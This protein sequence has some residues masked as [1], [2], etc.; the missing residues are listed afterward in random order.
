MCIFTSTHGGPNMIQLLNHNDAKNAYTIKHYPIHFGGFG[1]VRF[2]VH[3]TPRKDDDR[4]IQQSLTGRPNTWGE[5]KE[6][7]VSDIILLTVTEDHD[8]MDYGLI[9]PVLWNKAGK[10]KEQ[11]ISFA[12]A[13]QFNNLQRNVIRKAL[14]DI[15]SS[16]SPLW[17]QG[18]VFDI[19]ISQ[20]EPIFKSEV[21]AIAKSKLTDDERRLRVW[22]LS[23]FAGQHQESAPAMN[24]REKQVLVNAGTYETA[25]KYNQNI[26]DNRIA[27]WDA[28]LDPIVL[29]TLNIRPEV[30][31]SIV[32]N[33]KL[34]GSGSV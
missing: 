18:D 26:W 20:Q 16:A 7:A 27:L 19:N 8:S 30:V 33:T 17:L 14:I 1:T 10:T 13:Y 6:K 34:V 3:H 25:V 31:Q 21:K 4:L 32:R 29:T 2:W 12:E 15:G 22:K 28:L 9:I 23:G 5:P 24:E 11:I